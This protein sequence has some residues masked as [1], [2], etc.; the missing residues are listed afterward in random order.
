MC[1]DDPV[2]TECPARN[3]R[4]HVVRQNRQPYVNPESSP[5]IGLASKDE[6]DV[7]SPLGRTI[8]DGGDHIG[9]RPGFSAGRD[10]DAHKSPA[11]DHGRARQKGWRRWH[12]RGFDWHRNGDSL[13]RVEANPRCGRGRRRGRRLARGERTPGEGADG[14]DGGNEHGGEGE[15]C[16]ADLSGES[17]AAGGRRTRRE[18]ADETGSGHDPVHR[19]EGFR[20]VEG[21]RH[22]HDADEVAGPGRVSC[23]HG[24]E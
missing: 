16:D 17:W 15:P 20:L 13:D 2:P 4:C 5:L 18:R 7:R 6:D 21:A 9:I 19:V 22:R 24:H 3:P 8:R 11:R 10:G 1:S 12:K 23:L 14:Q